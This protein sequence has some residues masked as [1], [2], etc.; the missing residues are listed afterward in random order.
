MGEGQEGTLSPISS[1]RL[2]AFRRLS[3]RL[4]ESVHPEITAVEEEE[5]PRPTQGLASRQ[6]WA[7][8]LTQLGDAA[9]CYAG[10]G[11]PS[12]ALAST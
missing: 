7:P 5:T 3:K 2:R 6:R 9:S 4:G 12:P 11:L 10:R 8:T 1:P